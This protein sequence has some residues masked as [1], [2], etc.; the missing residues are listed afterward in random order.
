MIAELANTM[1]YQTKKLRRPHTKVCSFPR[2]LKEEKLSVSTIV[3]E[4]SENKRLP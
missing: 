4:A 3:E 1:S 2:P